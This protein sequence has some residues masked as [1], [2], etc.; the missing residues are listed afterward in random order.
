MEA[1][2]IEPILLLAQVVNISIIVVVLNVLL[3]KPILAVLDKRK[4]DIA[5]N[6]ENSES[7]KKELEKAEEKSASIVSEAKKEGQMIIEEMKKKAK[8]EEKHI[9]EAARKSA[10]DITERG[11]AAIKKEQEDARKETKK[12]AV[13]LAEEIVVRMFEGTVS[14]DIQHKLIAKTI[15]DVSAV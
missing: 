6:L 4:K 14:K 7:V 11:K 2:G 5:K 8:N 3:Y 15:K 10:E 9:L 13:L 12:E 1:L